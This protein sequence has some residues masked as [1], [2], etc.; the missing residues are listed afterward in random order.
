[1][2]QPYDVIVLGGYFYDLIFTGLPQMPEL[3]K[4]IFATGFDRAPGGA[5]STVAAMHRLE[6][7][8]GWACDFGNDDFSR[9]VVDEARKAGLDDA[10]F[11]HHDRPLRMISVAASFPQDRAFITFCDPEPATPA[12]LRAVVTAPARAVYLP[13]LLTGRLFAAGNLLVKARRMKLIMDC[14]SGVETL[15]DPAVR[16]AI[17]ALDLFLP[18]AE[19]ACRL[20]GETDAHSAARAL[21]ELCPLV[22]VKDGANGAYACAAGQ[23][24]H[25]P[26]IPVAC[27]DTTGAGD[28]FNAGFVKAWLDGR[29]VVE[30]LRWGNVVG[31]LST[32]VRG[33]AS[34]VITP[35]EV[36][37]WL[38]GCSD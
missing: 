6:L 30:C 34:Y 17:R 29:P 38:T 22:V 26:A 9:F 11:V 33:G 8:V 10:L 37:R 15:A 3:G 20:T 32:T 25:A 1:M 16:Q 7:R 4:E 21:G 28:A 35:A 14:S 31:G 27:V 36:D 2:L 12:G 18:N 24:S 19:E 13:G 5:Y 23:V